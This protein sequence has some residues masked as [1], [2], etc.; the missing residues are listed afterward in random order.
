MGAA[1]GPWY[2]TGHSKGGNLAVYAA[3]GAG[4]DLQKEIAAVRSFD[5]PGFLEETVS[6][7]AFAGILPRTRTVV[8]ESSV[9]GVLLEHAEE[10]DVVESRGV[11][12]FQHDI[13]QWEVLRDDFRPVAKRTNSSR[14]VDRTMRDF[15]YSMTPEQREKGPDALFRLLGAGDSRTVADAFS[16]RGMVSMLR[17]L[18]EMDPESRE[19]LTECFRM[20]RASAKD[21]L[22][23]LLEHLREKGARSGGA[24]RTDGNTRGSGEKD[25]A[26]AGGGGSGI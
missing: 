21:A 9:I 2:L 15:L 14:F 26:S 17:E 8:P 19:T 23:L 20:L 5:G 10:F 24:L 4:E 1:P 6:G 3:A 16:G 11:S 7:A 13:Y 22:P 18:K 25:P 12:V